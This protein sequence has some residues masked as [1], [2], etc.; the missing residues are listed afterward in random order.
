[1]KDG[2]QL[3]CFAKNVI[4]ISQASNGT[5]LLLLIFIELSTAYL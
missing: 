4:V 5:P 2:W 3:I 1:M